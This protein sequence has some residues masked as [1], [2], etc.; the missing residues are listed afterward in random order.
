MGAQ[1]IARR[2]RAALRTRRRSRFASGATSHAASST[3]SAPTE[4]RSAFR[5]SP[6][7][8]TST[9]GSTRI[10]LVN[11]VALGIVKE[12]DDHSLVRAQGRR[13]LGDRARR[14]GDRSQ[15]FRR[16]VVLVVDARRAGC[17]A[18]KGAVQV[19]DP[20]LKNVLMRAT[21]SRLRAAARAQDCGRRSRISAPAASWDA[22]RRSRRAG[23]YGARDRSRPRQRRGRRMPPEVI[24]VGETQERLLWVLPPSIVP[25]VLRIYNEEFTLARD[26]VQRA[27]RRR[28]AASPPR[29]ATCCA[30]AATSSWTSRASFSPARFATSCRTPRAIRRT[31]AAPDE[32]PAVDVER[33]FPRVLAHRDVCSREPLYR[34][35]DAVV[36]GCTVLPRGAA[37]AGVLAPVPGSRLGVAL[38]VAGNPRYGRIDAALCRRARRARSD[39][40][41]RRRRRAS[42]RLDRLPQLRQS[43]QARTVRRV[44]RGRR[45]A[46]A[47]GDASSTCRS[48]PATSASTTNRRTARRFRRRRSSRCVGAIDDCRAW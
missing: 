39:A 20:F 22:R 31:A 42:D 28:S 19:P 3:G 32:L 18:N 41:R 40:P 30:I 29:G 37:D 44:R 4:T 45:R 15:R 46:G 43:A 34:R 24:A 14:Q 17:R 10:A 9:A 33:L 27:R 25:E 1:V 23:G 12:S 35:Y 2:R 8:S 47:R 48:S 11:V 16:R 38:A 36:R 5:T 13:G 7:T 26:C 21:L 6:A